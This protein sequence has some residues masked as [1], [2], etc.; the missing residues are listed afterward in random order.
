ME[1]ILVL[2]VIIMNT[3]PVSPLHIRIQ[4]HFHDSV[5]DCFTNLFA[6][7]TRSAMKNEM[8]RLTAQAMFLF[9]E[10]LGIE[11]NFGG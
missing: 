7:G 4:I 10:F 6:R 9:D 3:I 1:I 11:K 8:D 5:A 2:L